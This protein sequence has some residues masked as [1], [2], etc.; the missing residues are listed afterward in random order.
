[1]ELLRRHGDLV[2]DTDTQAEPFD[3]RLFAN[4]YGD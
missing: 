1:M 4:E 3:K 2:L